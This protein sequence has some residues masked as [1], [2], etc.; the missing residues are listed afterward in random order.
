MNIIHNGSW[1]GSNMA[2]MEEKNTHNEQLEEDWTDI[3][4]G[5]GFQYVRGERF[6]WSPLVEDVQ[7][8]DDNTR[9]RKPYQRGARDRSPSFEKIRKTKYQR[10]QEKDQEKFV[11]FRNNCLRRKLAVLKSQFN[12]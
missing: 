4:T 12:M 2:S 11:M 1:Q 5:L 10:R 9:V 6:K 8:Q 7:D 3:N